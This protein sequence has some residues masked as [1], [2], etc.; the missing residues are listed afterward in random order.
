MPVWWHHLVPPILCV[1]YTILW[2]YDVSILK[3]II[4]VLLFI[5]SIIG[6]AGFG[7]WLNDW[8]DIKADQRAG[9]PNMV[10]DLSNRHR[11]LIISALLLTAWLPWFGIPATKWSF[12]LLILLQIFFILYSV[13]PFRFKNRGLLGIICDIHYG[14]VLPISI[15][16]A[17]FL[18]VWTQR[19]SW[20]LIVCIILLLYIKGIRNIIEHQIHDRKND[21]KSKTFTFVQ[22]FGALP[23]AA[24]LRNILI[25]VELIWIG[26]LLA[27]YTPP[28]LLLYALYLMVYI[29][30]FS[31]WGIFRLPFRRWNF[32]F[33][34]IANDFYEGWLPLSILL[35]GALKNPF[36]LTILV[37]H[38]LLFPK[39]VQII[40]WLYKELRIIIFAK[41]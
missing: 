20:T 11:L 22:A 32:H 30:L 27:V 40:Q 34:Y 31:R 1:I 13:P 8:T 26:T 18:P 6:T 17:T 14:H 7:Y 23:T 39:S 12:I 28:L 19:W 24:L 33:W 36:F 37:V 2:I 16:M 21:F 15:A 41:K 35:L 5:I 9:K 3:I 25:P 38:V 10:A 29:F 4:P